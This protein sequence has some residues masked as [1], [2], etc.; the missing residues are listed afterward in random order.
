MNLVGITVCHKVFGSGVVTE[1]E[2]NYITV[3]FAEKTG[4]FIYPDAFEKFIKAEQA[5]TQAEIIKAINDAKEAAEQKR[6]AEEVAK[7]AA[8]ELKAAEA[9]AQ[10]AAAGKK[11]SYSSKPA[12]HTQRIEGQRLTFFVFQGDTFDIESAGGFVWAPQHSQSGG[13]VFHWDNMLLVRKGDIILHG[14]NGYVMAASVAISDCYD[15]VRPKERE[16][17]ESWNNEGRRIDLEYTKFTHPIKT[18]DFLDD[19]LEYCRVKY[20]PFDKDGNGNMGYLYELN[21]KLAQVFVRAAVKRNPDLETV[22]YIKEL[23]AEVN[24][25]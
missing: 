15:C 8:E 17:E 24:N 3:K 6:L 12:V 9:A 23:L 22:D 19:I 5:D 7:K 1:H 21:R 2:G 25:D 18:S 11:S 13:H 14:C 4:K 20:S 10:Q 16:F